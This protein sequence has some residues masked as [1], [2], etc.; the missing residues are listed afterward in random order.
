MW[1]NIKDR[2]ELRK[3]NKQLD[4]HDADFRKDYDKAKK[5]CKNKEEMQVLYEIY[6]YERHQHYEIEIEILRTKL[7]R[8]K[9]EKYDVPVP[10]FNDEEYWEK[11]LGGYYYLSQ[12]GRF[13][14]NRAIRRC[15]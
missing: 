12:K 10:E 15:R 14:L 3:L 11:E 5:E 8:K 9:A 4:K 13:E 7:L 6:R 2:M 1:Q